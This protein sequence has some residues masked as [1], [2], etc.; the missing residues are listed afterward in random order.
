[1]MPKSYTIVADCTPLLPGG[2]NGGAK[3]MVTTLIRGLARSMPDVDFIL[4]TTPTNNAEVENLREPNISTSIIGG[5]RSSNTTIKGKARKTVHQALVRL[6]P[7]RWLD[8]IRTIYNQPGENKQSLLKEKQADLLFCPF[9]APLFYEPNIPTV[10][11]VYDL[12]FKTF[13]DFFDKDAIF[14]RA[15]HYDN[16]VRLADKIITISDFTKSQA[17]K[18]SKIP[19]DKVSTIHIGPVQDIRTEQ[20][21]P[22]F[23]ERIGVKTKEFLLYPANDWP[24]KNHDKLIKAFLIYL[25]K[26]PKS[27][28]KIVC[29][30]ETGNGQARIREMISA[31]ALLKDRVIRPGYISSGELATLYRNGLALIFPSLYEGF[32]IPL[33]EAMRSGLPITCSNS[34]SLPEVGGDAALYFDPENE[35][36]IADKIGMIASSESLRKELTQKGNIR[37]TSME[38]SDSF[39]EKYRDV[40]Y[41]ILKDSH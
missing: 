41:S 16:A 12:L 38:T 31:N 34:T 28:L 37:L 6:L 33:I 8:R 18:F 11:I 9:T 20:T 26:N 32:G 30:G 24:H 23:L 39:T 7:A 29:P 17:L 21:D 36:D 27:T 3:L 15:E 10:T 4:L 25:T 19:P 2:T 40:L 5:Q 14:Y 22:A 35:N 1:M 13:P